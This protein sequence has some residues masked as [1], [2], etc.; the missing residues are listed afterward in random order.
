MKMGLLSKT[1]VISTVSW[2]RRKK[3][4][5]QLVCGSTKCGLRRIAQANIFGKRSWNCFVGG[6]TVRHR[7]HLISDTGTP[8]PQRNR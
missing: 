5:V 8:T 2:L 4:S 6:A 1:E 7:R 3:E